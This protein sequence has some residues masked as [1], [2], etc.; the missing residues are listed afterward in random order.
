MDPRTHSTSSLFVAPSYEE[1]RQ[2]NSA[3]CICATRDGECKLLLN[4]HIYIHQTRLTE[5]AHYGGPQHNGD[6]NGHISA[7]FP[8]IHLNGDLQHDVIMRHLGEELFRFQTQ[9]NSFANSPL[10]PTF[11]ALLNKC[12]KD[13]LVY[14]C[15]ITIC[16]T[17]VV[18]FRQVSRTFLFLCSVLG[19]HFIS[20]VNLG[21]I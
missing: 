2:I 15:T 13:I 11:N 4:I 18:H 1:N 12:F 10:Y 17:F 16:N 8:I 9:T 7:V 6:E 20:T 21:S 3:T 5:N 14:S 19:H